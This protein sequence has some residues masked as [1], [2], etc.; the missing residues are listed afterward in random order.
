VRAL[1]AHLQ[2]WMRERVD[3]LEYGQRIQ[4]E[5]IGFITQ[6][7]MLEIDLL[8]KRVS[9]LA[10]VID[11]YDGRLIARLMPLMGR[12]DQEIEHMKGVVAR[13]TTYEPFFDRMLTLEH[14]ITSKEMSRLEKHLRLDPLGAGLARVTAA[15]RAR[16]LL[17]THFAYLVALVSHLVAWRSELLDDAPRTDLLSIMVLVLENLE[18][19]H[20]LLV[21]MEREVTDLLWPRV[22]SWGAMRTAPDRLEIQVR[23]ERLTDFL[24]G[25]GTPLLSEPPPDEGR[26]PLTLKEMVRLQMSNEPFILGLLENPKVVTVPGVV[27]LIAEQTRSLRVLDRILRGHDLH[28]GVNKD[29]PRLLLANPSRIPV[30]RIRSFVHVRFVSKTDLQRL[31]RPGTGIRPEVRKE[32][33]NYLDEL[34]R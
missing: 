10:S 9:R 29:V 32:I 33:Y 4:D 31:L 20:T 13:L 5:A 22:Q 18:A 34:K 6:L 25:D 30:N 3:T 14:T 26:L 19:E 23:R 8:E 1:F 17:D 21:S 7:T 11:P 2:R 28:T 27:A 12:Y 24:K 16:P 15:M